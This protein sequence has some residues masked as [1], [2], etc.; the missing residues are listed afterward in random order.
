MSTRSVTETP[1]GRPSRRP[2]SPSNVR[3]DPP[4]LAAVLPLLGAILLLV[5]VSGHAAAQTSQGRA[6]PGFPYVDAN[7]DAAFDP[8]DGDI[9]AET[10]VDLLALMETG[11]FDAC[12]P[13]G[14]YVPPEAPASL[15]IPRSVR[16]H[17]QTLDT[18]E[19]GACANLTF[20]GKAHVARGSLSLWAGWRLV[21]DGSSL[22]ARDDV[23]LSAG[24]DA[25]DAANGGL[26]AASARVRSKK[27]YVSLY[28]SH[29]IAIPAIDVKAPEGL[30]IDNESGRIGAAQARLTSKGGNIDLFSGDAP[31]GSAG[32]VV[33][34]LRDARLKALGISVAS[35]TGILA[36][37]AR[38]DATEDEILL[39][40]AG[41][42]VAMDRV[43]M[44]KAS[45]IAIWT[46]SEPENAIQGA[47]IEANGARLRARDASIE[48][49]AGNCGGT[50]EG[51]AEI[52]AQG[53]SLVAEGDADL[54]V[55]S[56]THVGIIDVRDAQLVV[57][58]GSFPA[59]L[60]VAIW[61]DHPEP[62]ESTIDARGVRVR[63]PMLPTFLAEIVLGDPTPIVPDLAF[64]PN[65]LVPARLSDS[66]LRVDWTI[67]NQ[68]PGDA[69]AGTQ[70]VFFWS[71]DAALDE[72]DVELGRV[73]VE[74]A[75]PGRTGRAEGFVELAAPADDA[76]FYVIGV[77]DPDD[78]VE[79]L[80][81]QNNLVA[82]RPPA[83]DLSFAGRALFV[84]LVAGTDA[85]VD[86]T[87]SNGG[88]LDAPAGVEIDFF[89][90][91]DRTLD[92]T[93]LLLRTV[94]LADPLRKR[95]SVSG[96]EVF[97]LFPPEALVFVIG[98]IDPD[99]TVPELSETNNEAAGGIG[100]DLVID[101]LIARYSESE[102]T[103]S[104]DVR[105]RNEGQLG[106]TGTIET[107]FALLALPSP[108]AIPIGSWPFD[109]LGAG[110]TR[111]E[112]VELPFGELPAASLAFVQARTDA[113]DAI[114]EIDET[115]NGTLVNVVFVP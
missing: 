31:E 8:A 1:L 26:S 67:V 48:F 68:G 108:A 101:R 81:E 20:L 19:L 32:D 111:S 94:T 106:A 115:N 73:A 22:L 36:A 105:I 16:L 63:D 60:L 15:V 78:D 35:E 24:D 65:G 76:I 13:A 38:V 91:A 61:D 37:D 75:L 80:N 66:E 87:V 103:F 96:S 45:D 5:V 21:A 114:G 86:W 4:A 85:Q 59:D 11:T 89:L 84:S 98:V 47:R 107:S 109:D 79:E 51:P 110:E 64:A 113:A 90:S 9:G 28:A 2:G 88:D 3:C 62:R 69:A 39:D 49:D 43:R 71:L 7:H 92:E 55:T 25:P 53:M 83:P 93:D 102:G 44:T 52:I 33:V 74:T 95:R 17:V 12:E 30:E 46:W 104:L 57:R 99:D 58:E 54:S 23:A 41:G 72:A 77:L 18:L 97:T 10:G 40:S 112:I 42:L 50:R 56:R 29:E 27:G 34:D 6:D 70:I 14:N 82:V 100:P